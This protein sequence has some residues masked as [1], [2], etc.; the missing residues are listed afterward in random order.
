[1]SSRRFLR[2]LSI[3]SV[4]F[5][6]AYIGGYF[7]LVQR[8]EEIVWRNGGE[9]YWPRELEARVRGSFGADEERR[10]RAFYDLPIRID[11]Y[12]FPERWIWRK[13]EAAPGPCAFLFKR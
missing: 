5:V 7:V 2:I 8:Q 13:G 10:I 1:M 4:V 9:E 3:V 12:L 11:R 6:L